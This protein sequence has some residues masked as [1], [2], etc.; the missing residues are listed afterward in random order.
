V[1]EKTDYPTKPSARAA[2]KKACAGLCRCSAMQV[3]AG[4]LA[5]RWLP[6]VLLRP[7]QAWMR[8]RVEERGVSVEMMKYA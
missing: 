1:I 3:G 2:A 6:V 5:G 4:P 7:D 8:K